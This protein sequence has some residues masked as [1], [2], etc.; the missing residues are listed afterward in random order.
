MDAANQLVFEKTV[1]QP[2]KELV[3]FEGDVM[4]TAEFTHYAIL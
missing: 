3:D 2:E 1:V 4:H